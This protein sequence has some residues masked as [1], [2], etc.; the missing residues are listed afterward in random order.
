MHFTVLYLME[1]EKLEDVS[2]AL[3]EEEFAE[4][5]CDCCGESEPAIYGVCDWFQ[6]GG[7][8]CDQL[9]AKK[10]IKGDKSWGDTEESGDQWFSIVEI[11]DL[12]EPISKKL[13]YAV[14]DRHG[15]YC[16]ESDDEDWKT[17]LIQKINKKE[18]K[19]CVALIDCH[20]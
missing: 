14:A 8:W 5:F 1:G 20:D 4:D 17:K 3:V 13:I 11:E 16:D 18:I 9:K 2:T 6:V 19:G 12:L 7:R 10:G 15:Y